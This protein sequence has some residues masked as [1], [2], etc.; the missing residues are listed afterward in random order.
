M[1][2]VLMRCMADVFIDIDTPTLGHM[3]EEVD[4]LQEKVCSLTESHLSAISP[5]VSL[6]I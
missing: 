2:Q 3:K 1:H 6:I 4:I 5:V